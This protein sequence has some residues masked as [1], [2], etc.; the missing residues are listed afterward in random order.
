MKGTYKEMQG[1]E[2][3]YITADCVLVDGCCA[4]VRVVIIKQRPALPL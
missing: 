4:T 2:T 1:N 3:D